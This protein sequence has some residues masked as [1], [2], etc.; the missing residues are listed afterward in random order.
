MR[1]MPLTM[2]AALNIATVGASEA[3]AAQVTGPA[4]IGAFSTKETGQLV[5]GYLD[6]ID[7]LKDGSDVS[8][9]RIQSAVASQL[10]QEEFGR[11]DVSSVYAEG[12]GVTLSF[13]DGGAATVNSASLEFFSDRNPDE[14]LPRCRISFDS[15][16]ERL[17]R[18]DYAEGREWS[19]LENVETWLFSKDDVWIEVSTRRARTNE[20]DSTCVS[21]IHASEKWYARSEDK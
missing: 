11:A 1:L 14:M 4:A 18:A 12:D 2:A 3:A 16:R 17:L 20:S 15:L 13:W 6:Y 8:L 7:T 5:G 21:T 9:E 19:D 10:K